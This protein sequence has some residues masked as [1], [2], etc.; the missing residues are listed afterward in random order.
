MS[1]VT[2]EFNNACSLLVTVDT[3]P[4][5]LAPFFNNP[6]FFFIMSENKRGQLEEFR[7]DYP[8][9]QANESKHWKALKNLSFSLSLFLILIPPPKQNQ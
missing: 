5:T 7:K 8:Q 1:R 2:L 4:C 9:I 6:S 3:L